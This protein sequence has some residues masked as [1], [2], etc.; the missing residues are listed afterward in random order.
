MGHMIVKTVF[1]RCGQSVHSIM[2]V[3]C[4]FFAS[5]S[6]QGSAGFL[7]DEERSVMWA[8]ETEFGG[9]EIIVSPDLNRV[10]YLSLR[11]EDYQCGGITVSGD[12]HAESRNIWPIVNNQ[13]E[14]DTN[15]G[16]YQIII[17]GGFNGDRTKISGEWEIHAAGTACSGTWESP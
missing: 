17:S 9:F 8:V 14:A 11:L 12:I 5:S 4:F 13:F 1:K 7:S 3:A 15:L 6:L 16:I 10:I 2:I